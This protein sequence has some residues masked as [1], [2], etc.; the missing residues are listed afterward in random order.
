MIEAP[1]SG[2]GTRRGLVSERVQAARSPDRTLTR[3]SWFW[4]ALRLALSDP[5]EGT[6]RALT[7]LEPRDGA[8]RAYRTDPE[9]E[10]HLHERLG[11]DWPC[12]A[13]AEFDAVW[14]SISARLREQ[15]LTAGR[16]VYGGW[17]DADPALARAVWCLA[18]HLRA[19]TVV[20]TGVARGVTT[21]MILEAFAR[22]GRG[23][24][25]SVD[26]APLDP[27]LRAQ[28]GAAVP[29]AL[30]DRWTLL[31]GTS[32][33]RL[34]T[35]LEQARQLD[36]FVHDSVHTARNLQF[37]LGRAW[38]RLRAGGAIVADDIERNGAFAEFVDRL[39]GE[40]SAM[41]VS[42]DDGRSCFGIAI[43]HASPPA[44]T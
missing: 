33:R 8:P 26:L 44:A 13:R 28:M 3:R 40:G 10:L 15:G 30:R 39:G 25:S 35:A 32:R 42:A 2:R 20:E 37:E 1:R 6:E 21:R 17:D 4:R 16:G 34:S 31:S 5:M 19:E 27:L 43:K 29:D 11:V 12:P 24:L 7:R 36:L 22:E 23:R 38:P 41:A 14:R 9:W 18:V